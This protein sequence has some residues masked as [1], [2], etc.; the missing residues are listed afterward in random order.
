MEFK[1][2]NDL[3]IEELKEI[4]HA[5][6]MENFAYL[7]VGAVDE[8]KAMIKV[9]PAPEKIDRMTIF[10]HAFKEIQNAIGNIMRL[11]ET[12]GKR[13]MEFKVRYKSRTE[14]PPR[15][16]VLDWSK[17]M[18]TI[19]TTAKRNNLV[20]DLVK[21]SSVL[22]NEDKIKLS[23][24]FIDC[25]KKIQNND[26]PL[27]DLYL[28]TKEA[29]NND[30]GLIKEA[31]ALTDI[32]LDF[33]D[34]TNGLQQVSTW[35][36]S[37]QQS[38][39]NKYDYLQ[40]NPKTQA[41][42]KQ[43][44]NIWKQVGQLSNNTN[45][46]ISQIE[47]TT[48]NMANE[49]SKSLVPESIMVEGKAVNI[50]WE[51]D[52]T[53]P[54]YQMA[55]VNINNKKYKVQEDEKGKRSLEEIVSKEDQELNKSLEGQQ[56]GIPS[57]NIPSN[58]PEVTKEELE[59]PIE[60]KPITPEIPTIEPISTPSD[61]EPQ[62]KVLQLKEGQEVYYTDKKHQEFNGPAK[63]LRIYKEI[64]KFTN[65]EE[66]Y[67]DVVLNDGSKRKTN[68]KNLKPI[69]QATKEELD[70]AALASS[71]FNLKMYKLANKNHKK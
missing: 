8:I 71:K 47:Q 7:E 43:L 23:Q 9:L 61:K 42:I 12:Y 39:Q 2:K 41:F 35:F 69:E 44:G 28:L 25:A 48:Q 46:Q 10:P 19:S 27:K 63:I 45:T 16:K 15:Y 60:E 59:F 32:N 54:G 30:N 31:Q 56:V 52:P 24:G 21:L 67:A 68:L 51:D 57:T 37:I 66:T 18:P 34:I 38:I 17:S 58:Q 50:E 4:I 65:K 36:E 26:M 3:T 29:L 20:R 53:E 49:M 6:K 1:V 40:K 62:L 64:A 5:L 55:V 14:L 70:F 22:E 33:T 11:I 13:G